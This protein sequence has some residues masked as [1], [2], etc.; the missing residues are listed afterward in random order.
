MVSLHLTPKS[1][2]LL[3]L[4]RL[5]KVEKRFLFLNNFITFTKTL[6]QDIGHLLNKTE[7]PVKLAIL[8]SL[9]FLFIYLF[10]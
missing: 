5:C 4:I 6:T 7:K 2:L 3:C 10:F 9:T 1:Q 8:K